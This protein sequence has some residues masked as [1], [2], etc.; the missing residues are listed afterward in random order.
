[1]SESQEDD[2]GDVV[3]HL[4]DEIDLHIVAI[5]VVLS[6][7]A[8]LSSWWLLGFVL[9]PQGRICVRAFVDYP[10]F[11]RRKWPYLLANELLVLMTGGVL[12][13]LH[14]ALVAGRSP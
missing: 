12:A 2:H 1:M 4:L 13:W 9:L 5:L 3:R 7:A 6:P 11:G 8:L 14:V 10:T